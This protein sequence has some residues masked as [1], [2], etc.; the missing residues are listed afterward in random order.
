M[1]FPLN[2]CTIQKSSWGEWKRSRSSYEEII[3][4]PPFAMSSF[5]SFKRVLLRKAIVLITVGWTNVN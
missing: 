5:N 2:G 1:N 4:G 3:I